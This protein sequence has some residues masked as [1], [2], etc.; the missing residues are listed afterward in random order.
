MDKVVKESKLHAAKEFEQMY[1]KGWYRMTW[2]N[3]PFFSRIY[4]TLRGHNPGG[5]GGAPTF[6]EV[7]A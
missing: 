6:E 7:E 2:K 5:R 3:K 1:G 4:W